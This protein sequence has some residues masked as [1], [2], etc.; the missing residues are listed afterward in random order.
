MA[1]VGALYPAGQ[2]AVIPIGMNQM[3]M[4]LFGLAI[5]LFCVHSFKLPIASVGIGLG[6]LGVLL[7]PKGLSAPP[8]FLFMAAFLAWCSFGLITSEYP[9]PVAQS[10]TDYLKILLIFFVAINAAKTIP[11]LAIFIGLWVLMFGLYPARGTYFNF[12]MGINSF[13]RYGWNFSFENYN[14]LAAYTILVMALSAFLLAG[15][16]PK[17]VRV[18]AL[19]STAGLALMVVIT[20]SRGGFIAMVTGFVFMLIRS[21]SRAKLIRVAL[22]AA[23]GIVL[24]APGAVWERFSRMKYLFNTETLGEADSS[25]EQ[26]YVLL[27]VALTI[28]REHLATGVGLGAYP[29]AHERYAAERQEWSMGRGNRDSHNMYVSLVAE[30]GIPALVLFLGMVGS[31]LQRAARTE[32]RLRLRMP[33]EAEQIRILR[34]G[35][36]AYL[37]AAIFGSLHRV[38]FLYLYQAILWSASEQFE[39]LLLAAPTTQVVSGGAPG[40][41]G[42]A[43][44]RGQPFQNPFR[45]SA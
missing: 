18:G 2:A 28:A 4:S 3:T 1:P 24:F 20:Q 43:P 33:R 26:R 19:I 38:S 25:A 11:Q 39:Q 45:R 27:Q 42:R 13:G 40:V 32:K 44:M 12:V 9:Q 35:L 22:L 29:D 8:P 10:L 17:W 30:G 37:I 6:M 34:Y 23:L 36:I 14:D 15:R 16:F 5:Y 21:R 31:T 41:R 7:S